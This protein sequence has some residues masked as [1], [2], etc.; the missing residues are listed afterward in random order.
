MRSVG[1]F[2]VYRAGK[3]DPKSIHTITVTITVRVS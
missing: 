3:K 1:V 2:R